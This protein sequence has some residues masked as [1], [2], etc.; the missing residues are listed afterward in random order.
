MGATTETEAVVGTLVW[1]EAETA[2]RPGVGAGTGVE[3][4]AV[5]GVN[6]NGADRGRMRERG[7]G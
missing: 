6:M 2:T 7:L 1:S 3:A 4:E 5:K